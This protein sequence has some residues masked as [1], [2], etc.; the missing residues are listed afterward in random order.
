MKVHSKFPNFFATG[1]LERQLALYDIKTILNNAENKPE[2]IE[3]KEKG[4]ESKFQILLPKIVAKNVFYINKPSLQ[5]LIWISV[6]PSQFH[7]FNFY[8]LLIHQ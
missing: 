5:I 3:T 7:L 6:P 8:H 4:S 2:N 1:G